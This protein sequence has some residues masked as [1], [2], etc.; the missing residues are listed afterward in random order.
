MKT[1]ILLKNWTGET[2]ASWEIDSRDIAGE[3]VRIIKTDQV[4]L[5]EGDKIVIKSEE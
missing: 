1:Y 3:L 5:Q 4:E 2:I